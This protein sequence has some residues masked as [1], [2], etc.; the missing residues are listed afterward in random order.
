VGDYERTLGNLLTLQSPYFEEEYYP[1]SY[2][3]E[4]IV[5]YENCRYPEAR[6]VLEAFNRRYEPLYDELARITAREAAPAEFYDGVAAGLRP[7]AP[8]MARRVARLATT[9]QNLARLTETLTEI[10][11]EVSVGIS[12]R[13]PAFRDSALARDIGE[14][15][16]AGRAQLADEAGL[17]A[18]GK[19][20]YER[21]QLRTLL[22]QALRIQIE[23][24]RKEREALEGSLAVGSQVDVVRDLKYSTAVSDEHLYWPY[25]GEFWR[26]ELGTYSYTFTKGCKDRLNR[27]RTA[28]AP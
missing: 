17:R 16:H 25:E 28:T 7:G 11:A 24:S 13:S 15:L 2:V 10:D 12:R 8:A 19:L 3:L 9:D 26:D 20:E 21:D 18:R 23:V 6:Q 4:A 22:A 27:P 14:K 1:E 5:Y